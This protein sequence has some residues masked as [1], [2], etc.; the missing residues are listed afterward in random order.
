MVD[1][2]LKSGIVKTSDLLDH[3]RLGNIEKL[4]AIFSDPAVRLMGGPNIV[5]EYGVSPIH[6]AAADGN[7]EIVR[8]L[9]RAGADPD[10]ATKKEKRTALH[11]A[12]MN[13][14]LTLVQYLLEIEASSDVLDIYGKTALRYAVNEDVMR[15]MKERSDLNQHIKKIESYFPKFYS[16]V[17][18]TITRPKL[19]HSREV[20]FAYKLY[21]EEVKDL[22]YDQNL[23]VPLPVV[24]GIESVRQALKQMATGI[25]DTE[26]IIS[27]MGN[28]HDIAHSLELKM[29][30][31]FI[32]YTMYKHKESF[33]LLINDIFVVSNFR[34]SHIASAI[35]IFLINRCLKDDRRISKVFVLISEMQGVAVKFFRSLGFSLMPQD[36]IP[37]KLRQFGKDVWGMQDTKKKF[38][39]LRA[40]MEQGLAVHTDWV[41]TSDLRKKEEEARKEAE[42]R[43]MEEW[44]KK[45]HATYETPTLP[46][47][48][49]PH[50]RRAGRPA[51]PLNLSI[52]PQAV[53]RSLLEQGRERRGGKPREEEFVCENDRV[54]RE[55]LEFYHDDILRERDR[56]L[57]LERLNNKYQGYS[58]ILACESHL[59]QAWLWELEHDGDQLLPK[60]WVQTHDGQGN[61]L[62]CN[63]TTNEDHSPPSSDNKSLEGFMGS[64]ML[65][66]MERMEEHKKEI[67][68]SRKFTEKVEHLIDEALAHGASLQQFC[69]RVKGSN[70][71]DDKQLRYIF[72][73]AKQEIRKVD[74]KDDPIE[75]E[76]EKE[77]AARRK[78]TFQEPAEQVKAARKAEILSIESGTS[79]EDTPAPPAPPPPHSASERQEEEERQYPSHSRVEEWV[80]NQVK[81]EHVAWEADEVLS[82]VLPPRRMPQIHSSSTSPKAKD[83]AP[84]AP[85]LA[86]NSQASMRMASRGRGST[87]SFNF[88]L[89]RVRSGGGAGVEMLQIVSPK[90]TTR[91]S[92]AFSAASTVCAEDHVRVRTASGR[93]LKPRAFGLLVDSRP[94]TAAG[95]MRLAPVSPQMEA[96]LRPRTSMVLR[97]IGTC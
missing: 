63:V 22:N 8:Y 56:S 96:E 34:R 72:Q 90:D 31:A 23:D 86:A 27:F 5:D 20:V 79:D 58:K 4:E 53:Q 25:G 26:G 32:K 75:E 3:V 70:Q 29:I 74:P 6:V 16:Y 78:I 19:Q 87:S 62:Y 37:K 76:E 30:K 46:R 59:Q 45:M 47:Q 33:Q 80:T 10:L 38:E 36:A 60:D 24:P 17:G 94:V 71:F 64:E 61:V 55:T 83:A 50:K 11:Y 2:I 65:R 39:K 44:T 81:R 88:S 67:L 93:R 84:H 95:G 1:S 21:R 68:A 51:L 48:M 15:A 9:V 57:A 54:P 14:N 66:R 91:P 85:L 13:K 52:H 43:D 35:T 69:R 12:T 49:P 28:K 42:S 73:M 82:E 77:E 92:T 41:T 97:R 40:V 7:F 89:E 18:G